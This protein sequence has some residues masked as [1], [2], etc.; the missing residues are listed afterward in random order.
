MAEVK[1]IEVKGKTL[2]EAI[3]TGLTELG[4]GI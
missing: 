4:L 2:D 1:S 3:F